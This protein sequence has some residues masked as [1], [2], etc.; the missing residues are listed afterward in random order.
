MTATLRHVDDHVAD[1]T[2]GRL[3]PRL[4]ARAID[5]AILTTIG[6]GSGLAGL[7]FGYGWLTLTAAVTYGYFVGFDAVAGTT[8]GKRTLGLRV[9]G[10]EGR[11]PTVG[12]AAKREAFVLL[13]AVPFA[14]PVL[15]LAAGVVIG[16]TA[17]SSP[18]KQGAHDAW[19]NGTRVTYGDAGS[20]SSA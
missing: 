11:R 17:N 2:V 9:V 10:P 5:A 16:T 7:G 6:V 19:A 13:G 15:S 8:P 12:Q 18:T 20:G 1:T 4:A 3:T 14:G